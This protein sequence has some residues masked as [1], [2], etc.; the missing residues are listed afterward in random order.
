[1][2]KT[3]KRI[4]LLYWFVWTLLRV[5]LRLYCRIKIV[6]AANV[7]RQGGIILASNHIGAGDPFFVGTCVRREFKFMAKQ[8]LFRN[9][10]VGNLI[11]RL[12]A[13][14]VNRGILDPK[15]LQTAYDT[16][17]V[18]YGLIL[19]PEGTRSKT[20]ELRKGK[21]G[22]GLLA[23]RVMVPIVP[24]YIENSRGFWGIPFSLRRMKVI[25]GEPIP[26]ARVE[27]FPDTN[28]GYRALSEEL[29]LKIGEL[30]NKL[31][32]RP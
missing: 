29:M 19:F 16:L 25:F 11:E 22:V 20:G 17:H 2:R 27:G 18:G 5:F 32:E 1:M 9:F 7:P 26:S 30:K 24:A 28:D 31:H 21:P 3:G 4:N 8:E 13:F 23:R 14:P 12:N 6:G 10:F 15:A